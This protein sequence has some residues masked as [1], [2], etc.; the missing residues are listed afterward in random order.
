MNETLAP[1]HTQF[2]EV[3]QIINQSRQKASPIRVPGQLI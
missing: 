1:L 3:V 2:A